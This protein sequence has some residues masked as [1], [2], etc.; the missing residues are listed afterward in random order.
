MSGP[1][2]PGGVVHELPQDLCAA[3]VDND[4]ALAAWKDITPLARNE[5]ICWV[6]DAK[7]EATRERRIRRT[8][9]ELEEGMRRPC[10]WPGCAH[11]ERTG[12]A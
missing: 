7:Q 4:T 2:V 9:E 6:E 5:F 1:S 11:R 10:C 8:Q 12:R 3:L